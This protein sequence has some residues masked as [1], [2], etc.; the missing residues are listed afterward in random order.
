M[1]G[2]LFR[3]RRNGCGETAAFGRAEATTSNSSQANRA[4]HTRRHAA[5]FV[6]S[7]PLGPTRSRKRT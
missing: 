1:E 3:L 7:P 5:L 2:Q 4:N 6:T